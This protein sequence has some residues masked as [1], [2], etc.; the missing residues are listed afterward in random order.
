MTDY[1]KLSLARSKGK[2]EISE[3]KRSMR[4]MFSKQEPLI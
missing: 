4:R 3:G 1:Q 2:Q